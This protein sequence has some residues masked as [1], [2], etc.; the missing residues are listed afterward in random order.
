MQSK[1]A[2]EAQRRANIA[3]KDLDDMFARALGAVNLAIKKIPKAVL[4]SIRSRHWSEIELATAGVSISPALMNEALKSFWK[5]QRDGGLGQVKAHLTLNT[6]RT[7]GALIGYFD[8]YSGLKDIYRGQTDLVTGPVR[9]VDIFLCEKETGD[10]LITLEAVSVSNSRTGWI[11]PECIDALLPDA[12]DIV[13]CLI[14][15]GQLARAQ[16]LVGEMQEHI[17]IELIATSDQSLLP[18]ADFL[19]TATGSKEPVVTVDEIGPDTVTLA[20]SIDELPTEYFDR[21]T[22]EGSAI[23]VDDIE[24]G[25][26]LTIEGKSDG[27]VNIADFLANPPARGSGCAAHM[28]TVGLASQDLA[29]A[30]AIFESLAQRLYDP[31]VKKLLPTPSPPQNPSRIQRMQVLMLSSNLDCLICFGQENSFYLARF[32]PTIYSNEVIAILLKGQTRPIL[33]VNTLRK[34]KAEATPSDHIVYNYGKWFD[35]PTKGDTWDQAVKS[36]VGDGNMRIGHEDSIPMQAYLLLEHALPDATF[37]PA[38]HIIQTCRNI[39]DEDEI[40]YARIAAELC[41][42]AMAG[43]SASL[44]CEGTEEDAVQA[45]WNAA[46][47]RKRA[48]YPG[49]NLNGFG[50]R[51]GGDFYSIK[52]WVHYGT[53]RFLQ[54]DTPNTDKIENEAVSAYV[55]CAYNGMHAKLERTIFVGSVSAEQS[56]ALERIKTIRAKV[57]SMIKP[58]V[59]VNALYTTTCDDMTKFGYFL[60]GRISHAIGLGGHEGL[61][62]NE[63]TDV[64]LQEGMVLTIEPNIEVLDKNVTT[65]HS[66]TIVVTADG[67]EFLA[68]FGKNPVRGE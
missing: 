43:I 66:D 45:G 60:P 40:A 65:Q 68:P 59:P 62:I 16:I 35:V 31:L 51:E 37:T 25:K 58:G 28:A 2:T 15:A 64:E 23:L 5:V 8:G 41:N 55:W 22:A 26:K 54:V 39:K 47:D 34:E 38:S 21:L 11:A 46:Y 30:I 20:L 29:V 14:G 33:I 52:P 61:S 63:D 1:K 36:V 27:V 12:H 48:K 44:T 50:S 13:I 53:R 57:F 56:L 42:A 4:D 67:Y 19:I 3:V 32:N 24:A 7:E 17:G 10:R 49:G 9:R 6:N 18:N